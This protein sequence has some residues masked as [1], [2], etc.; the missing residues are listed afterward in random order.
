MREKWRQVYH[1]TVECL[2]GSSQFVF[3]GVVA[4]LISLFVDKAEA[5]WHLDPFIS[6]GLK[7]GARILFTADFFGLVK[8]LWSNVIEGYKSDES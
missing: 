5:K 4:I 8:F 3:V 7:W 2:A 1:S 6:F